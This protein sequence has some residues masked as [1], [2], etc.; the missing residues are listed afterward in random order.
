M[1]EVLLLGALM[2]IL[3][4][5]ARSIIGLKGMVDDAKALNLSPTDLFEAARLITSFLIGF[6][7]G[8][9]AALVYI[10][11]YGAAEPSW[12]TLLGFVAAG[13]A[14]TDFLEGFIAQYLPQ[15]A[16]NSPVQKLAATPATYIAQANGPAYPYSRAETFVLKAFTTLGKPNIKDA[17]VLADPPIAYKS[18]GDFF[19]LLDAVNKEIPDESHR[20]PL[21]VVIEWQKSG[22]KVAD[23]VASVQNG[24]T[25][26]SAY[27]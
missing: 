19:G 17:D 26:V 24:P 27:A 1:L 5:G 9:A 11:N 10:K 23:V 21:G 16:P 20:L 3:G 2:G 4:Q 22:K 14:G 15:R 18:L 7:V 25:N 13:Y 8:L 12:H 6:L